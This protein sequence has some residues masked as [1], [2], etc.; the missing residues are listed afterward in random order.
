MGISNEETKERR[1]A[2]RT[3]NLKRNYK[4]GY[5]NADCFR[6]GQNNMLERAKLY[7]MTE[8]VK[9]KVGI[10]LSYKMIEL[11]KVRHQLSC[12]CSK[13]LCGA[14]ITQLHYRWQNAM[15]QEHEVILLLPF[16]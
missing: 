8:A 3:E 14:K 2:Q 10:S 12:S 11:C 13:S 5:L 9:A 7:E 15:K 16:L 4:A 6:K 1:T